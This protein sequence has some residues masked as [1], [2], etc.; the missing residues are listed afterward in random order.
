MSSERGMKD[1]LPE[2]KATKSEI[3]FYQTE[4][5][6][7]RTCLRGFRH[8][9]RQDAKRDNGSDTGPAP[10]QTPFRAFAVVLF[11]FSGANSDLQTPF[12]CCSLR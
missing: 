7:S 6:K 5:G 2:P 3:V 8:R 9:N 10:N 12:S 4:D 1:D 11:R